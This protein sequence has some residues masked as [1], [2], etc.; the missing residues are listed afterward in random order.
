[1]LE[2][3]LEVIDKQNERYHEMVR[4][5]QENDMRTRDQLMGV[6]QHLVSQNRGPMSDMAAPVGK[7]VNEVRQIPAQAEPIIIDA[8]TAESLRSPE[9]VIVGDVQQFRGV[10]IALDTKTG[11]FRF[12]EEN[13]GRELRGKITDPSLLVPQNVYSHALDTKVPIAITAKPTLKDDGEIH[14]LFVSHAR[15]E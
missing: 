11:T 13:T 15:Q 7:T 6:V 12:E 10:V 4:A 9:E 14:K 3:A 8:P 1:V 5:T 2:K